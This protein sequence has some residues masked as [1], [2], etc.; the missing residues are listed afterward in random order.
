MSID[1]TGAGDDPGGSDAGTGTSSS[2]DQAKAEVRAEPQV[3]DSLASV[4]G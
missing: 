1:D 3:D 2:Q 4:T